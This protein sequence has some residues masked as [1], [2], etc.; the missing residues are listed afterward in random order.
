MPEKSNQ[1]FKKIPT[2][3]VAIDTINVGFGQLYLNRSNTIFQ[4]A[5]VFR[6]R[7]I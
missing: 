6:S 5:S 4:I 1:A 7:W 2:I 3:S